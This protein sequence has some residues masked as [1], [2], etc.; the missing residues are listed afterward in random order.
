MRVWIIS[1]THFHHG[2]VIDYCDRPWAGPD[3]MDDALVERW[4]AHVDKDDVVIH[5]GDFAFASI[6]YTQ[7]ILNQLN[8]HIILILGNHDRRRPVA[9]WEEMGIYK[10]FRKPQRIGN[11][12]YL[13]HEP[14]AAW[15]PENCN[16]YGHTHQR[17]GIPAHPSNH[18]VCVEQIGYAPIILFEH[19]V[20][21]SIDELL[22]R[23]TELS[24]H[25]YARVVNYNGRRSNE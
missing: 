13:S 9:K 25:E 22:S 14:N 21:D 23:F 24:A 7:H 4:N 18:C 12:I 5:L 1:D 15:K 19:G 8:G 6:S 16:I 10:A 2:N 11:S 20:Y 3:E 17:L